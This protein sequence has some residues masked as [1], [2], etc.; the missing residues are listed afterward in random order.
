MGGREN[1]DMFSKQESQIT[2]AE[3]V[4]VANHNFMYFIPDKGRGTMGARG[5]TAPAKVEKG[6]SPP[7]PPPPFY[8]VQTTV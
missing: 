3:H 4:G 6:L 2:L 8:T 5:A 1:P 7:P